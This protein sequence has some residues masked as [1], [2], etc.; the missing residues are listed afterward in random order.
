MYTTWR[1]NYVT[2][3][4]ETYMYLVGGKRWV[5]NNLALVLLKHQWLNGSQYNVTYVNADNTKKTRHIHDGRKMIFPKKVK[6]N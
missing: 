6:H 4:S 1:E 2:K 5:S 3:G